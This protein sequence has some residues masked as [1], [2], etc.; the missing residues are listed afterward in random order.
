MRGVRTIGEASETT[1]Q[2]EGLTYRYRCHLSSCL[3]DDS[4]VAISSADTDPCHTESPPL[5]GNRSNLKAQ[6]EQRNETQFRVSSATTISTV[7]IVREGCKWYCR[8]R[9]V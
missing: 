2:I 7:T 3:A 6:T 1:N 4:S 5:P 8:E 9:C